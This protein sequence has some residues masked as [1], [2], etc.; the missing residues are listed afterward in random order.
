ML[1]LATKD[2][3]DQVEQIFKQAKQRMAK[4]GLAQWNDEGDYPNRQIAVE[5]VQNQISYVYEINGKVAGMITINDDFYDAYPQTPNP[6]TSRAIHRVAVSDEFLGQGVG[7]KL[8]MGAEQVVA[9][10]GYDTIIVDTFTQNEKMNKLIQKCG[11]QTVGEFKLFE[12]LPNWVM[13]KKSIKE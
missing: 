4:E 11:Y 6:Q 7:T 9:D 13:Y 1:R 8:Y 2:D 5:D 10:L 12:H 3:I